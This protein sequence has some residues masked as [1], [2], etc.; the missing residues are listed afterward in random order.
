MDGEAAKPKRLREGPRSERC[1]EVIER[2]KGSAV[3]E[4]IRIQ[5]KT[6]QPI[7]T[8]APSR[9][10]GA[11]D[12]T[13]P[14]R[15][16]RPYRRHRSDEMAPPRH[17]ASPGHRFRGQPAAGSPQSCAAS[18]SAPWRRSRRPPRSHP[19]PGAPRRR[20]RS[21]AARSTAAARCTG[22]PRRYSPRG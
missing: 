10:Q 20:G 1:K 12:P 14:E 18:L 17:S 6:K 8:E 15:P 5:L 11:A 4:G 19:R 2:R 22:R 3:R 13:S 7:T 16:A 9:R 21:R